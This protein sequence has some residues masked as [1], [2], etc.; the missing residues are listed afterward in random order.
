L[1]EE[2]LWGEMKIGRKEMC[3]GILRGVKRW[4]VGLKTVIME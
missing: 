4:K 1:K 3:G 2:E